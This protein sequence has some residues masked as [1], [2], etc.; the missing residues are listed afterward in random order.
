VDLSTENEEK[1]IKNCKKYQNILWES[2]E[3]TKI[4]SKIAKKNTTFAHDFDKVIKKTQVWSQFFFVETQESP[5]KV[6][7]GNRDISRQGWL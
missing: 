3:R 6:H 5:E 1:V 7:T 4:W 2:A